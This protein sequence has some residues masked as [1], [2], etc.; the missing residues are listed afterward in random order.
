MTSTPAWTKT[1]INRDCAAARRRCAQ[2]LIDMHTTAQN[3]VGRSVKAEVASLLTATGC[4]RNLTAA[5]PGQLDLA[6]CAVEQP[7]SQDREKLILSA[8]GHKGRGGRPGL[9]AHLLARSG[10]YPWLVEQ[11]P[12]TDQERTFLERRLVDR[13]TRQRISTA[14]RMDLAREQESAVSKGLWTVVTEVRDCPADVIV[15]GL[16][17]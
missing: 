9:L 2:R 8:G 6:R 7:L 4:L 14:E 1:Q 15:H 5:S 16:S 13:V 12:A 10:S 3:A 17:D 11:R